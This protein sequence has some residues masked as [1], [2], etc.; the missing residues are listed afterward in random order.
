MMPERLQDLDGCFGGGR[1]VLEGGGEGWVP[2]HLADD[3]D[4]RHQPQQVRVPSCQRRRAQR[5]PRQKNDGSIFKI[6]IRA[7]K[8]LMLSEYQVIRNSWFIS[9]KKF[10]L[11]FMNGKEIRKCW[12][13]AEKFLLGLSNHHQILKPWI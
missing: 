1:E 8:Y 11:G 2:R 6:Q 13:A 3:V 4:D 10:P 5:A 12:K 7:T 9:F